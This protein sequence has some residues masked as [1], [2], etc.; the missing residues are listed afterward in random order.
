MQSIDKKNYLEDLIN[1]SF[2]FGDYLNYFKTFFSKII[3]IKKNIIYIG[4]CR[5]YAFISFKLCILIRAYN[6]ILN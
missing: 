6:R 5:L 4:T 1:L 3:K 2:N